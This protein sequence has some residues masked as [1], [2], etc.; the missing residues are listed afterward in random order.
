V[1]TGAAAG[2]FA[3][4]TFAN[5]LEHFNLEHVV[6]HPLAEWWTCPVG[7]IGAWT[8]LAAGIAFGWG[9][10]VLFERR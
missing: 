10:S 7:A 9:F 8:G 6:N 4:F 2:L 1:I 3:G 5:S